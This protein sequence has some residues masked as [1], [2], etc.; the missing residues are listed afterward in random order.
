[1]NDFKEPSLGKLMLGITFLL[2]AMMA[3]YKAHRAIVE[4]TPI[5]FKSALVSPV[6]AS[7]AA[8]LCLAIGLYLVIAWWAERKTK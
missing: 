4:H 3:L 7:I 6:Q 5:Q 1:V 8:I 2:L